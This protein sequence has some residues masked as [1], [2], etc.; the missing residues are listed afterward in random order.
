MMIASPKVLVVLLRRME[1]RR[2]GAAQAWQALQGCLGDEEALRNYVLRLRQ[3]E[4]LHA[5]LMAG[6]MMRSAALN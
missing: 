6:A 3:C 2:A 5:I 4:R 1:A